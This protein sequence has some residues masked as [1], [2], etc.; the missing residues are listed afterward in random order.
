MH[1]LFDEGL[2]R[3]SLLRLG[4]SGAALAAMPWPFRG[5]A[6]AAGAPHLSLIHI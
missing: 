4:L 2:T 5:T 6:A 3:R 1:R